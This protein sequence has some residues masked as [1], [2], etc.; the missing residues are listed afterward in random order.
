M[1][2][3]DDTRLVALLFHELAH[4][5][6]YIKG[7]TGFN[8]SFATAVEEYGVRAWLASKGLDEEFVAYQ[9]A[10]RYRQ[11]VVGIIAAARDELSD[12]YESQLDSASRRLQKAAR[13]TELSTALR[14]HAA[15]NGRGLSPWYGENTNNAHLIS[16]VLYEGLLPEFR[17]LLDACDQDIDCFYAAAQQ[18]SSLQKPARDALLSSCDL[19]DFRRCLDAQ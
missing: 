13:L 7:D 6:L 9:E 10:R 17:Q 2:H 11:E 16:S 12:I 14:Q 5:V 8:E 1:M 18:I 3:W 4:Q 19:R 15:E